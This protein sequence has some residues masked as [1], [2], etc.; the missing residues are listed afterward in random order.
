MGIRPKGLV[1]VLALAGTV[2][3]P[4]VPAAS[5]GAYEP[6]QVHVV[7]PPRLNGPV[8]EGYAPRA[9]AAATRPGFN[10]ITFND[11]NGPFEPE[12]NV[13]GYSI[14]VGNTLRPYVNQ[15]ILDTKAATRLAF[16]S[17]SSGMVLVTAPPDP[18]WT[19]PDD[20]GKVVVN[21]GQP[22]SGGCAPPPGYIVIGCTQP[23]IGFLAGHPIELGGTVWVDPAVFSPED[24]EL[25]QGT[26]THELGHALGL[27]HFGSEVNGEPTPESY[28]GGELQLMYPIARDGLVRWFSGDTNGLRHLDPGD[29]Q[30][31]RSAYDDFLGRDADFDGY[32]SWFTGVAGQRLSRTDMAFGLAS[33]SEWIGKII[34]DLYTKTLGRP[35][36]AG[37]KAYW[38]GRIQA[39]MTV[40]DVAGQFYASNEYFSSFGKGTVPTWIDDLYAKLLGRPADAGGRSFWTQQ[41]GVRGRVAVAT[42]FFQSSESR[43][44]R[45]DDLYKTLLGRSADAGG[46]A[47]W[48]DQ[49]LQRGD[50]ALAAFLAG[51]QEYF[52]RSQV[53][54][55]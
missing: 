18:V 37:G 49:I 40:A 45:V 1:A 32:L 6:A 19:F 3:L 23:E 9:R 26:L 17:A 28:F 39:G 42:E 25:L 22:T 44:K 10:V 12:M 41:T 50:I 35:A 2:A 43:M 16:A 38:V 20:I 30:F 13:G 52:A 46:K 21:A 36:D 53:Y 51:S 54:A 31:V 14:A 48:A 47:F 4:H 29:G 33:T 55:P 5:A 34:D 15:S 11:G 24:Q 27:D 7:A 8:P